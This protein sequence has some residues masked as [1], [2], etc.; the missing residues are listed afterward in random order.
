MWITTTQGFVSIVE[1]RDNREL[2]Q[3]RARVSEDITANFPGAE[4][5]VVPGADYRYRARFNRRRVADQLAAAIMHLDYDSHFKDV[6]LE[7]SPANAE[8]YS[9]YYGTWSAMA[10]MQ[11]FAPYSTTPRTKQAPWWEDER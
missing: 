1:D 3:I 5:L 10:R 8:R 11:D 7:R 2:L 4:V 6:A 9:A